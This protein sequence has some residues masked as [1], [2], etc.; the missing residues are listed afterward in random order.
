MGVARGL[1]IGVQGRTHARLQLLE[2]RTHARVA[3]W[4]IDGELGRGVQETSVAHPV[5]RIQ[6]DQVKVLS[7]VLTH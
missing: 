4:H 1:N 2:Q 3:V 6:S 5:P 7:D